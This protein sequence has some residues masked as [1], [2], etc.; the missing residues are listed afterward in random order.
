M[1][2]STPGH[3]PI[4]SPPNYRPDSYCSV[5]T[6]RLEHAMIYVTRC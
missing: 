2:S 1:I 4:L 5:I 6:E 3:L